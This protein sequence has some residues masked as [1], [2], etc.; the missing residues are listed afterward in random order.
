VPACHEDLVVRHIAFV[1]RA[2][3][4]RKVWTEQRPV[5]R[6]IAFWDGVRG[7]SPDQA[8]QSQAPAARCRPASSRRA[9]DKETTRTKG[10]EASPS[11]PGP[12]RRG[13]GLR[14]NVG[15]L[16]ALAIG[17]CLGNDARYVGDEQAIATGPVPVDLSLTLDDTRHS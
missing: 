12:S 10:Y 5:G 13:T 3:T 7:S 1:L 11:G 16:L 6:P 9:L 17:G 14:L 15:Q 4:A 2:T 8:D